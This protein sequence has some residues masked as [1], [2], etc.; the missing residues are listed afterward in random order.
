MLSSDC[1]VQTRHAG[2][3]SLRLQAYCG[4]LAVPTSHA[5]CCCA[6][7]ACAA[8]AP[9]CQPP[10]PLGPAHHL[11]RAHQEPKVSRQGRVS[12]NGMLLQRLAVLVAPDREDWYSSVWPS[13]GAW[14]SCIAAADACVPKQFTH[15]PCGVYAVPVLHSG[16]A[17]GRTSSRV[18][19]PTSSAC[20]S[21]SPTAA[22]AP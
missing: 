20:S 22:W 6:D 21:P 18:A 19:H 11:Y 15:D 13:W 5:G 3:C 4:L 16:T 1:L 9:H 14:Q 10:T 8:G 2:L 17:S 12:G 7:H